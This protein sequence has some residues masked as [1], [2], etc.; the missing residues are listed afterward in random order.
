MLWQ[1]L[2]RAVRSITFVAGGALAVSMVLFLRS[3]SLELAPD[4]V[5]ALQVAWLALFY[6]L[7]A[8]ALLELVALSRPLRRPG[9]ALAWALGLSGLA[10]FLAGLGFLA[11]VAVVAIADANRDD[12]PGEEANG[13]H[14]A[15]LVDLP[16]AAASPRA[17]PRGGASA[18]RRERGA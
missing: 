11:Y 3:E 7:G 10:A 6:A 1:R 12:A 15:I 14:A 16:N 9:R 13:V 2:G 17:D 18:S 4:L 8:G 5:G